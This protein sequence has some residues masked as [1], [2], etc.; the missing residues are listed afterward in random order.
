MP[1]STRPLSWDIFCNVIDNYGDIGVCWR[2]ARQLTAEYEF[3]VRL[4]VDQLEAFHRI[5][6][7]I[8]FQKPLQRVLGVEVRHWDGDF[9]TVVPGDVVVEAF[10]CHLP[11]LF[12]ETMSRRN[13][14]PVWLNLDYLSAET[15]VSG[16]HALPSP[17]PHLPLT[18]FF[19]F[20]GFNEATGGLLRE[21][22]LD[23]R[24][25]A[26]CSSPAQLFEFWRMIGRPAPSANTLT[27]SLFS[28]ENSALESLL[29][30]WRQSQGPICCLV[31]A[32]RTLPAIE[33]FV[34]YRLQTGDVVHRGNLE[35]RVLPFVSQSEYD[36][37]LWLCDLN[38]VRGEDSFVRAQWAAKPLLWHIYP[39]DDGAHWAKLNAFLDVYCAGLTETSARTLRAMHSVWNGA[40]EFGRMTLALW[41]Q[42]IE[43]RPELIRHAQNWANNQSIQEDLCSS[44]VRFCRSKL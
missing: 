20:P 1:S 44:L 30:V 14:L 28:Y 39:Q 10:A 4:W 41:G 22:D 31:P 40:G 13:P 37:L 19:F 12:V 5:C 16:C 26:F 29:D 9:S 18:K 6:P 34:G 3:S 38:F 32:T 33:A 7:E 17:H 11:D 35:I 43:A 42:W 2:L 23:G 27:V 8:D 15:W 21:R 25:Q 24:R 36:A